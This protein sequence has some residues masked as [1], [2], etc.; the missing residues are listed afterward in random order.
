MNSLNIRKKNGLKE[1]P[2]LSVIVMAMIMLGCLAWPVLSGSDPA[3]MYLDQL[4]LAPGSGHIFGT[5]TL[6]R[7]IWS[8]I[9]Y[10][11]L[12][13]LII[14]VLAT[15]IST[16]IAVVYG[17]ISGMAGETVD[18]IMM[19]FTE[20]LLSI[21][22][23]LLIVFM[24]AAIGQRNVIGITLI[25]GITGWMNISKMVRTEVRKIRNEEF[26]LISKMMGGSFFHIL[27]RHLAPN[28]IST[29]MFMVVMNVRS[30]IVSESTLSFLGI[31]LP[32]EIITWGSMLSL[33]EKALL[34]GAW[35]IILIPGIF[36]VV[37][38]LCITSIGNYIRGVV[39]RKARNL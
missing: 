23:I 21:P 6:G 17:T 2:W 38:L 29:I 31:G 14:G 27:R 4:N 18:G 26:V 20:I 25:I 37:T 1:F 3:R 7:D 8:L 39:N 28:F 22:S 16:F 34:S 32:V 19:R 24:Q 33:S 12:R 35:W 5:D 9:W 13:S 10:G 36:L 15:V 30:A 11:G